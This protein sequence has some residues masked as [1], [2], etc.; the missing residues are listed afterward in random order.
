MCWV[1]GDKQSFIMQVDDT[2]HFEFIN[3]LCESFYEHACNVIDMLFKMPHGT[4]EM[5]L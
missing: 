5:K 4:N 2:M 3:V 1:L